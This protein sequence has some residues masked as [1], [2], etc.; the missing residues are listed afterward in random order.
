MTFQELVNALQASE[1]RTQIKL[2]E[3]TLTTLQA[4]FKEKNVLHNSSRKSLSE[5]KDNKKAFT[6]KQ[7]QNGTKP[8][9]QCVLTLKG[10]TMLKNT[11][12]LG[13][14]LN[15]KSAINLVMWK[16]YVRKRDM[17]QISKLK[18]QQKLN[19]LKSYCSWH[20]MAK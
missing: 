18:S 5:K 7:R 13:Q 17:C 19:L 10:L 6:S 14:M 9:M 20:L 12:G 16:K 11:I 2:K 15:V 1:A 8:K 4:R 3:S